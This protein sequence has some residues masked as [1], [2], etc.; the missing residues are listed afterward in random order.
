MFLVMISFTSLLSP[1]AYAHS[2]N[3]EGFSVIEV[4]EK[5]LD[6][7]L[8]LDLTELGHSINKETDAKQLI[9]S[10]TVQQYINSHISLYADGVKVVGNVKKQ[11]LK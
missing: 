3:S 9:D 7:E 5:N 11:M 1:P 4:N 10:K 6:Y 2:N 8:K